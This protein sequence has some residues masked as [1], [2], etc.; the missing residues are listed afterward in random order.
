MLYLFLF[1]YYLFVDFQTLFKFFKYFFK[2]GCAEFVKS[3][4]SSQMGYKETRFVGSDIFDK[5][6]DL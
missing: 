5:R 2:I 1:V 3:V 4:W 6:K